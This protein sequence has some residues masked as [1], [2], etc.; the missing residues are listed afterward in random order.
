MK[1]YQAT[2]KQHLGNYARRRLGV[3][4]NGAYRGQLYSYV[5]PPRLRFLNVLESIRAELQD[6]LVA[7]PSITL[8]RD[9]HHLNSSQ[10]FAFNLFYP[11]LAAGGPQARALSAS[12]GIDAD[13]ADWQFEGVPDQN[14][15]TNVDVVWRIPGGASVFCEVKLSE[16]GFGTA[17]N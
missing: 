5:L 8:H 10:A 11:F 9:F 2:L 15:G 12:L 14:E 17:E 7:H 16:G 1:R 4:E 3:V 6:H 13:V